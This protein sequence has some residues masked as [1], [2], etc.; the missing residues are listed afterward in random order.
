MSKRPAVNCSASEVGRM[1]MSLM[2]TSGDSRCW[3][4]A[5]CRG[6]QSRSPWLRTSGIAGDRLG[7]MVWAIRKLAQFQ[8]M[9]LADSG[10][11]CEST[12]NPFCILSTSKPRSQR[13]FNFLVRDCGVQT[14]LDPSHGSSPENR[15]RL[16]RNIVVCRQHATTSGADRILLVA[17]GGLEP[18]TYGL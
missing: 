4:A 6:S 7:W 8:Q 2:Q 14:E 3:R 16:R 10:C 18:P 17:A 11:L 9:S 5:R 12:F 15:D 13:G 1:R